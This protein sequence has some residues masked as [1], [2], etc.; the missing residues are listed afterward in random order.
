M[1][2]ER[3]STELKDESKELIP[4][5][6]LITKD[7]YRWFVFD[8]EQTG[9]RMVCLEDLKTGAVITTTLANPDKR[10]AAH[11]AWAGARQSRAPGTPWEIMH[12]MGEKGVDPDQKL[13]DMFTTYG[14]AS[15]GDMARIQMDFAGVPMHVP[16]VCFNEG[17]I[18]SGQ[19][20]STRYQS[21]FEGAVL[22]DIRHYLPETLSTGEVEILEIAYQRLGELS[23]ALFARHRP[24]L[25]D[26]FTAFYDPQ[27]KKEASSL[28]SRVLDCT[29]Y[30]L[31]FG[32]GSGFSYET[33]ARDWSRLIGTLKAS[34]LPYY[35]KV[36]AQMQRILT[37]TREEEATLRFKAEAPGLIRHTETATLTNNNLNALRGFVDEQTALLAEV[38]ITTQFTSR[39]KQKVVVVDKQNTEA[40]RMVTQYLLTIW[41]GLDSK[42]LLHW[43]NNLD[44]SQKAN[45]ANV[46]FRGHDNYHEMEQL[47][48]TTGM[49]VIV[50][51]FLGEAR[52]FNRH[53][54]MGR[55]VPMPI[56][57]GLPIDK[58]TLD[59]ILAKGYGLPT[60]LE[61]I[62][63]FAGLT[64]DFETSMEYYY[65]YFYSFI[66][67]V[68][69]RYGDSIDYSFAI[70]LLPLAH[71]VDLW[72]HGDPKQFL[73]MTHQRCRPGGHINYRALAYDINQ[74]IANSDPYLE[75]M[76]L[77]DRPDPAN[78][79]EFFGRS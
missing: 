2:S 53:R 1:T 73:Y 75:G 35:Q 9:L 23:L 11:K 68:Y 26:A 72:M 18:V 15:V 52:D 21:K 63:E 3:T 40:E 37:P 16:F 17:T 77:K 51:G 64:Q 20:K 8:Q 66:D 74:E 76:R 33:S 27:N 5:H 36:G 42:Q 39:T 45:L 48:R 62:P 24:E 54:S 79:E 31:L 13:D 25:T 57:T 70:N 6:E 67:S 71:R 19:E 58:N 65:L 49:S 43:V 29:R 10:T 34:P 78:R 55:F 32:Q 61:E 41:P 14:H 47:A 28:S 59:Q 50:E 4:S 30:F 46:I 38:P 69:Q 60:Y 12:E 56:V 22:H 44:D 7:G